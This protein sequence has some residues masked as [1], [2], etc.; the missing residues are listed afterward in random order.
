MGET[1]GMI[2]PEAKLFPN[3][4]PVKLGSKLGTPKY[5]GGTSIEEIFLFGKGE[6]RVVSL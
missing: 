5:N 2:H 1:L 4:G 6:N 3:C